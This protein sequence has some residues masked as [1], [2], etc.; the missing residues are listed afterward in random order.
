MAVLPVARRG[1]N[2]ETAMRRFLVTLPC[3]L[4]LLTACSGAPAPAVAEVPTVP[5]F[6][7]V[8]EVVQPTRTP[9][10]TA[11]SL[12]TATPEPTAVVVTATVFNGGNVR[13]IPSIEGSTIL[14]QIN[15]N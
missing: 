14:D 5:V 8:T 3:A 4:F 2:L 7:T 12:P 1:D 9:E 11:T 10:P 13:S 6:P 15:A